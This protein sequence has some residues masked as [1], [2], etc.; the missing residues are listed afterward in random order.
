MQNFYYFKPYLLIG[1]FRV[2]IEK[3]CHMGYIT[4]KLFVQAFERLTKKDL[5]WV[6]LFS[7]LAGHYLVVHQEPE[8]SWELLQL[9]IYYPALLG[10]FLIAFV[11]SLLVCYI[12]SCLNVAYPWILGLIKRMGL[13]LLFGVVFPV[14]F[15][16]LLVSVYFSLRGQTIWDAEYFR[17]D[18]G[19]STFF[20]LFLNL[21]YLAYHLFE[22][23]TVYQQPV[24]AQFINLDEPS[25]DKAASELAISPWMESAYFYHSDRINWAVDMRGDTLGTSLLMDELE[26]SLSPNDFFRLQKGFIISRKAITV[27]DRA[28]SHRLLIYLST[29][30]H[31][32][33]DFVELG[34]KKVNYLV[35]PQRRVKAFKT[36]LDQSK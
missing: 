12:N 33:L 16:V 18:F 9:S 22:T 27:T 17:I 19:L 14:L 11:V 7:L 24:E 2:S 36:W 3:H 13:Q 5:L 21:F 15:L 35:V 25:N 32:A 23:L 10:S 8:S 4:A 29:P 28:S 26:T 30:Y 1:G 31:K 20:I 6:I 34:A